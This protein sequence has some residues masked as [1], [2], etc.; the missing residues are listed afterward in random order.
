MDAQ[1]W[2][3]CWAGDRQGF[4]QNRPNKHLLE[5]YSDWGVEPGS[6]VFVPLC[7]KSVDMDWL[8]GKGHKVLGVELVEKAVLQYFEERQ[9]RPRVKRKGNFQTYMVD[10]LKIFAGDVFDLEAK[11]L[12]GF[13]HI[14]DRASIVALPKSMRKEYVDLLKELLPDF[15]R[16]LLVTFEFD[17]P[18]DFGPPFTVSMKEVEELFGEGYSVQDLYTTEVVPGNPKF[19]SAGIRHCLDRALLIQKG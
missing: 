14:Y 4:D 6:G 16:I 11:D 17:A 19:V 15:G 2:H 1:F 13:S 8:L 10:R 9:T 12:K 18:E 7:G 5:A 3:D